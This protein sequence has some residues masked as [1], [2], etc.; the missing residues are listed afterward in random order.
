MQER[1]NE[2]EVSLKEL[3]MVV[4]SHWKLIIGII[5]LATIIGGVYGF[6]IASPSYESKIEGTISI[7]ETVDTKYGV[8]SYPSTNKMDYLSVIKSNRVLSQTISDLGLETNIENLAGRITINNSET[9][10]IFS[11][12]VT[13]G[14]PE[15]AQKLVETL[16]MYFVEEV[17]VRYKEKAVDF[18]SRKYYVDYQSFEEEAIRL[19]RDLENTQKLIETVEP[20]ITLRRLI[21]EDPIYAANIAS[22]R[23]MNLEELSEEMMLEEVINPHYD[24]LQAKIISLQQQ[25]DELQLTKE[26]NERYL[27]ELEEEK[28]NLTVYRREGDETVLT[29]GLLE[30]MQS[31]VLVNEHGSFPESPI[32]PRKSLILAI[33]IVLGGMI[34]VFVAFFKVYWNDEM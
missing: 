6:V 5:I 18:F 23:N 24:S 29:Y 14:S 2:E 25:M 8:Y 16:T 7:P 4:I 33:S 27:N 9:S 17:N 12:V 30:V 26:K 11:F 21:L 13:A 28:K 15:E 34:G 19:E 1:I 20:T 31:Q 3:I 10:S 22:N 32:A